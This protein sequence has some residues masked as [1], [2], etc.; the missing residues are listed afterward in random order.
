MSIYTNLD[1]IKKVAKFYS[2]QHSCRYNIILLNPDENGEFSFAAGSTYEYV[3]DTYFEK[4]RPHVI[5][6]CSTDD[7]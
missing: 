7:Y 6:I 1:S 2:H 5:R 4:S 3:R